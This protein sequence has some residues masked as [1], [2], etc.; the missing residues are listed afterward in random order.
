MKALIVEDELLA[1]NNL[2]NIIMKQFD[3]IEIVGMLSSVKGTIEWLLDPEHRTDIIL[4]DVEL[5]DGMCFDFF[6]QVQ[7]RAK[8]IVTTAYDNYAI[9]AFKISSI[10]YLLKPIDPDELR[11]AIARC[12]KQ[13][14]GE[15][16]TLNAECLRKALTGGN[17][18]VYKSRFVIR[19][20]DRIVLLKVDDVAY[21]HAEDKST[22]AV[23]FDGK[24][25]ILDMTLDAAQESVD[26][27]RFFRVSRSQIV[28][29]NAIENI[30]KHLNNRLKINIHPKP[31]FEI[32][33]S[34]FRIPDFLEWLE[35]K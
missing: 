6:E 22:Y 14:E 9:Q 2:R 25:Y 16:P 21:F 11:T 8:I 28:S 27:H 23:T 30:S 20:G 33:V 3:D 24:R 7:T 5:S 18:P 17:R 12:R 31:D 26:P 32:F 4:L 34:R 1:R 19:L 35:G 13:L 29:V 15:A 10:D